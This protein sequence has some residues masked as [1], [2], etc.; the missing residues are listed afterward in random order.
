MKIQAQDNAFAASAY[1]SGC[2]DVINLKEC[3]GRTVCWSKDSG[4]WAHIGSP[5]TLVTQ[6]I[7]LCLATLQAWYH[8][9][10]ES[11]T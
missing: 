8:P 10:P 7:D 4:Y 9:M 5:S 6:Y 3:E 1:L 11:A 2:A